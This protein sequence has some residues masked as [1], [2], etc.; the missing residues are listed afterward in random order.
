MPGSGPQGLLGQ[1]PRHRVEEEGEEGEQPRCEEPAA[2]CVPQAVAGALER[3]QEPDEARVWPAGAARGGECGERTQRTKAQGVAGASQWWRGDPELSVCTSG[4]LPCHQACLGLPTPP[5]QLLAG[6]EEGWIPAGSREG[7]GSPAQKGTESRGACRGGA[8]RPEG[9][10]LLPVPVPLP[11]D[12]RGRG[13]RPHESGCPAGIG[14]PLSITANRTWRP[15]SLAAP[16]TWP[17]AGVRPS[18]GDAHS[19]REP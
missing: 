3:V 17:R 10:G 12:Q 11:A 9:S 19:L 1:A 8:G 15:S 16:E 14:R 2:V 7:G 5:L 6:S 13:A 4:H 18:Q